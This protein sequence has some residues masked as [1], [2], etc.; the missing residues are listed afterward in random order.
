MTSVQSRDREHASAREIL[1][2]DP[3]A[4][5]V[6]LRSVPSFSVVIAAYQVADMIGD[7]IQ[8]VLDQTRPP[9]EVIVVDDGS[10]DEIESAVQP[11]GAQVKF[12]RRE[13]RGAAATMNA[14]VEAASGDYVC[15][16]GADDLFEPERL[17]A[18][19]GLV[20]ARPDIDVVTT[21]AWLSLRGE[22]F[23]RFNDDTHPFEA[24]NQRQ[25]ILERNFVFGHTA[26]RRARFIEV[27][28]FDESIRWTSDW[29]LWA[30]MI[31]GGSAVGSV[32][33]PLAKYRLHEETLSAKRLQQA[34][35]RLMT[36]GRILEHPSLTASERQHAER[37][38]DTIRR[39]I[40]WG[41]AKEAILE[42]AGDARARSF[43]VMAD[44]RQS[45]NVRVFALLSVVVPSL[46]RAVLTRRQSRYWTAAGGV[47]VRRS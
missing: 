31:L 15:F 41:E 13:H 46:T 9:L 34:R 32:N 18:L 17:E 20:A 2:P 3:V 6:A 39:E 44:S 11:F 27:G 12:L 36:C 10:T 33:E 4:P 24:K 43:R 7:A 40:E 25:A 23:R 45:L 30:R 19:G 16:I 38:A 28:G 35:G 5:V 29:E 22:V 8:S 1:A 21:D 47:R 37:T 14:G 26:V 42:H